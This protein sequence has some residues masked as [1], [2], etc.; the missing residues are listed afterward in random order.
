MPPTSDWQPEHHVEHHHHHPA[1]QQH[2]DQP[3]GVTHTG[4]ESGVSADGGGGGGGGGNEFHQQEQTQQHQESHPQQQEQQHQ[5]GDGVRNRV[6]KRDNH[7]YQS[8]GSRT[9]WNTCLTN[10]FSLLTHIHSYSA[11]R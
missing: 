4:H 8:A 11:S 1:E 7:S 10:R 5:E 9:T 6:V 3:Q 2:H